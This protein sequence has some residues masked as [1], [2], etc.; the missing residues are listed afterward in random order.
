MDKVKN[1]TK[2]PQKKFIVMDIES[3]QEEFYRTYDPDYWLYRIS[4]LRNAHENFG[5]IKKF[6][7]EDLAEVSDEDYKRMI[8]TEM[9]F[10]YFQMIETLFEIIFAVAHHDNRN[11]WVALTFSNDKDTTFYSNA[12]SEI[13]DLALGKMKTFLYKNIITTIQGKQTKIPLVRWLFY[14]IYPSKMSDEE[15]VKNLENIEKMLLAFAQDFSERGEYNAYKHSLRFYNTDFA[16]AISAIG[17]KQVKVNYTLGQSKD[18]IIFLEEHDKGNPNAQIDGR[19][20]IA[21]TIKPFDFERDTRCCL[22]IQ[23]LIKNIIYTRKYSLLKGFHNKEFQ[24]STY[25]DIK[26]PEMLLP[27]TGVTRSSFTV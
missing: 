14:F 18:S 19:R 12:Y 21:R 22:I 1:K 7:L 27:K 5:D 20:R 16:L 2:K 4:L 25:T 26:L 3:L 10:L 6:L 11:L 8:R 9:H 23:S 13:K 24:F 17:M 15:W